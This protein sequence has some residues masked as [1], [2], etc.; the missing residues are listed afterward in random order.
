MLKNKEIIKENEAKPEVIQLFSDSEI[1]RI[2][3]L[4]EKLPVTKNNKKQKVIKKRWLQNYND[5]LD[6]LYT[7]KLKSVLGEFKMDNLKTDQGLDIF[8]LFQESYSPLKLHVDSGFYDDNII[9]K[10]T[11]VPLSPFGETII[12]KN[13]WYGTSTNFTIDKNELSLS[14][15]KII[16]KN[17]NSNLHN[18]IFGDKDFD[19]DEYNKYLKHEDIKNLKGLE[20]EKVYKWKIGEILI[21]DRTHLHSSSCN[22][23]TKKLG[24]TTFT[25]K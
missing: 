3:D 23:Q 15:E 2:I 4:Y 8:G 14:S 18:E 5:E 13:R 25:K 12:Y 20:I 1:Q 11:L 22:I 17:S 21:F 16:G 7:E 9:Y 6:K 24:L 19:I 10:Q